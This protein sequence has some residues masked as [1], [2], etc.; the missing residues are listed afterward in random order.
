MRTDLILITT[1]AAQSA[2][3]WGVSAFTLGGVALTA[4]VA[5]AIDKRKAKRDDERRW[6]DQVRLEAAQLVRA[7]FEALEALHTASQHEPRMRD[8]LDGA[9]R[10]KKLTNATRKHIGHLKEARA[11]FDNLSIIAPEDV[12]NSASAVYGHVITTAVNRAGALPETMPTHRKHSRNLINTVRREIGIKE[13][14]NSR[15]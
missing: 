15:S 4:F 8:L 1:A 9:V 3:W 2:P 14:K 7:C 10:A 13:S 12:V 6:H 11:H 5:I